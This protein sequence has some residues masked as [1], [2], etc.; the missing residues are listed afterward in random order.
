MLGNIVINNKGHPLSFSFNV[1]IDG[2][3][4][5]SNDLNALS[6]LQSEH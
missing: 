4:D 5:T 2:L 3:F 1:F 6:E